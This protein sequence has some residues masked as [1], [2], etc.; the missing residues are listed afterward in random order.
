MKSELIALQPVLV[1][2][3]K[4]VEE[5]LVQVNTESAEAASVKEVVA[6]DEAVAS[7]KAQAA[8]AIKEECEAELAVAIPMLD[9]ALR[10][11][12]TLT[13]AD[14]TEVKAMKNPPAAVKVVMETVCHMLD[15]KAKRVNDPDKPGA[16]VDDFWTPSQVRPAA[17]VAR[18]T[19]ECQRRC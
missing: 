10:A 14:I 13:K 4:E 1:A 5:T 17:T 6:A 11:L 19:I 18:L 8:S 16:K 7:E 12:D 2:T 3:G 15:V 9:A